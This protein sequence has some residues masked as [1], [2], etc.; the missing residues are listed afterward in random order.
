MCALF[1]SE[2][3][4]FSDNHNYLNLIAWGCT[5]LCLFNQN[6]FFYELKPGKISAEQITL[7]KPWIQ[8][9]QK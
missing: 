4:V 5:S 8:L 9:E 2:T 3:E 1:V 6:L 7:P